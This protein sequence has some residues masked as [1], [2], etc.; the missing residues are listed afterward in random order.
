MVINLAVLITMHLLAM[1]ASSWLWLDCGA[2]VTYASR[3]HLNAR[4]GPGQHDVFVK[5]AYAIS[6]AFYWAVKM[7]LLFGTGQG[8]G[9]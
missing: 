1:I 2:T 7:F 4:Q 6:E 9:A 5:T 8:S 3:C